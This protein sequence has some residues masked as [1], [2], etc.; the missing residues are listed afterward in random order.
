M[1]LTS[2][3]IKIGITA[4]EV[5]ADDTLSASAKSVQHTQFD[6]TITPSPATI[7]SG[8]VY[9][10]TAGA[11]TIDLRALYTV[12]GAVGDGNG[13]KVQGFYFKNLGAN[14]MTITQGAS[15]PY[16]I[17]GTSGSVVVQPGGSLAI[18]HNDASADISGT[19]K[20]IDI[21]G[22]SSQTFEAGFILG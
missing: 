12:G 9:A 8:D 20:T 16:L 1:S 21:A 22:T 14:A 5:L 6:E 17:F 15:N 10:L 11:A 7:F 3:T 19:V 18:F 2:P 4:T 13:L